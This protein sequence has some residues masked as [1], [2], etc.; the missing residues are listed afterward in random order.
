MMSRRE[1]IT[2]AATMSRHGHCTTA[3]QVHTPD[4][5]RWVVT[6]L[7]LLIHD[8]SDIRVVCSTCSQRCA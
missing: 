2:I 1:A 6:L 8:I 7:A 5:P 3:T 4:G